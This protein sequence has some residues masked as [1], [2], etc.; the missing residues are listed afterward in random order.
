[1]HW[2]NPQQE[3]KAACLTYSQFNAL[4]YQVVAA[5]ALRATRPEAF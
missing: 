1:M 3:R 4:A 2:R 5:D